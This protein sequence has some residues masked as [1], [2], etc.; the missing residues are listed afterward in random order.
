MAGLQVTKG[1]IDSVTGAISRDLMRNLERAVRAARW[2]Q[3]KDDPY[4]TS[5][6]YTAEDI[7]ELRQFQARSIQLVDIFTGQATLATAFNF[8]ATYAKLSGIAVD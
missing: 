8:R 3:S 5:L 6:G 2:L 7:T 1:E 4:L